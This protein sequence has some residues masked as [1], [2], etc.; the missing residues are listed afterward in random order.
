MKKTYVADLSSLCEIAKDVEN[1]CNVSGVSGN[2]VF[3]IILAFD[4]LFTNAV[5]YGY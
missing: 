4:V 5:S 3:A 2:D 1:F